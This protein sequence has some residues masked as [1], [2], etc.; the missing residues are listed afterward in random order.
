MFL[1][2]DKEAVSWYRKAMEQ[3]DVDAQNNLGVMYA[4]GTGVSRD[5]KKAVS[6]YTKAAEQGL[7]TAQYNL[8]SMYAEGKGVTKNDKISY[9]WLKLAQYNGKEGMQNDFDIM[10]KRMTLIDV[11]EAK[12]RAKICLESDYIRCD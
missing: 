6:L 3:G 11:N 7:A 8:G 5:E 10:T 2:T 4:K 12:K 1:K 9:M